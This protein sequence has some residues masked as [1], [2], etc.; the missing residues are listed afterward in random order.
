L[1]GDLPNKFEIELLK[2]MITLRVMPS[3]KA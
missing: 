1:M 2:T 3:I